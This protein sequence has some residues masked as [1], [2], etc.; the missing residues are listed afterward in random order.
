MTTTA[1]SAV[2]KA[3]E[4]ALAG[5]PVPPGA[6]GLA[7]FTEAVRATAA[8]P[9]RPNRALAELLADGLAG[10]RPAPSPQTAWTR[11]RPAWFA[12]AVHRVAAAGA[13]ARVAAC[14]GIVVAGVTAAGTVGALPA[15]AQHTFAQVVEAA[16]TLR[17]PDPERTPTGDATSGPTTSTTRTTTEPARTPTTESRDEATPPPAAPL[18]PDTAPV[19]PHTGPVPPYTAPAP[20]GYDCDPSEPF[21]ACVS[22]HMGAPEGPLP[23]G[24]VDAWA[25][26]HQAQRDAQQQMDQAGTQDTTGAGDHGS[27]TPPP[28]GSRGR[29][30]GNGHTGPPPGAGSGQGHR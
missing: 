30:T 8:Q 13:M 26:Y 17:V 6:D 25:R 29:P 24:Q 20:P 12:R 3:F 11:P 10:D 19:P 27:A 28:D 14:A 4:A 1:D 5:R 2:E 9:G 15:G 22:Q 16:T 18:P 7:A 23:P 21:G